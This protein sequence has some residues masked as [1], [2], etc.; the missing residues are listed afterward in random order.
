LVRGFKADA[1]ASPI[2]DLVV[3]NLHRKLLPILFQIL[4]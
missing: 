2:V 3:V 4:G 1:C